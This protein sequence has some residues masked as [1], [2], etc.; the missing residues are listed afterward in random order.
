MVFFW[1]GAGEKRVDAGERF[2]RNRISENGGGM[3]QQQANVGHARL[4]NAAEGAVDAFPLQLDAH[5]IALGQF[6]GAGDQIV[7]VAE[8]DFQ[9]AWRIPPEQSLP[10]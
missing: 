5:K 7:A 6:L 4:H 10:I 9:L 8:P 3:S 2:G 1:P